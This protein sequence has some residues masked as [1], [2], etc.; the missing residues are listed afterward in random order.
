MSNWSRE[1]FLLFFKMSLSYRKMKG[2]ARLK[3]NVWECSC[4]GLSRLLY[5]SPEQEG[6]LLPIL[7]SYICP[8]QNQE[9]KKKKVACEN[10]KIWMA[11][12]KFSVQTINSAPVKAAA[13]GQ[14][15]IIR[16][17]SEASRSLIKNHILLKVGKPWRVRWGSTECM[18]SQYSH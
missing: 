1:C 16:E 11:V 4:Y 10:I 6:L 14:N 3:G 2:W 17:V 8:F 18:R 12:T 15:K 7:I 9:K 13:K 5:C